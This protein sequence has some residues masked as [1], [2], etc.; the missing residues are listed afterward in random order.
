MKSSLMPK[1]LMR[2]TPRPYAMPII[3]V[4]YR[5]K[6]KPFAQQLREEADMK[7]R[8]NALARLD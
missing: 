2:T 6:K 8:D 4:I 1:W 5:P 3:S 7:T